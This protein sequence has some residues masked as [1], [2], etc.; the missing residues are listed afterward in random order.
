MPKGQMSQAIGDDEI[1]VQRMEYGAGYFFLE[2]LFYGGGGW[3]ADKL[4]GRIR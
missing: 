2:C 1:I 4:T 3:A